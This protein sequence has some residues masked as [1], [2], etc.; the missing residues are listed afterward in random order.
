MKLPGIMMAQSP[1]TINVLEYRAF[2]YPLWESIEAQLFT[3][4]GAER[5]AGHFDD[6]YCFHLWH[7]GTS[8]FLEKVDDAFV[9]TS[10]S[11]YASIARKVEG[12]AP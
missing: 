8:N 9:R 5:F 11:I 2:F 6:A 12:L 10:R 1:E 7:G 3:D 4:R